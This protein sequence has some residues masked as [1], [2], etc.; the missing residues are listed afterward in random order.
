[1]SNLFSAIF[2]FCNSAFEQGN[3]ALQHNINAL[4]LLFYWT[5][6]IAC[7]EP[8]LVYISGSAPLSIFGH[9]LILGVRIASENQQLLFCILCCL[10]SQEFKCFMSPN[11]ESSW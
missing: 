3:L 4:L 1:M 6:I 5:P 9:N 10:D 11:T 2:M 8:P 7:F